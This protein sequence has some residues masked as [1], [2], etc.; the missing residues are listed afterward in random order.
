MSSA[1][2]FNTMASYRL[3]EMSLEESYLYNEYDGSL[4]DD[5]APFDE[6]EEDGDCY[7][8][9]EDD[10]IEDVPFNIVPG[11]SDQAGPS[12]QSFAD[13]KKDHFIPIDNVSGGNNLCNTSGFDFAGWSLGTDFESPPFVHYDDVRRTILGLE[14]TEFE[15]DDFADLMGK[16]DALTIKLNDNSLIELVNMMSTMGIMLDDNLCSEY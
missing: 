2:F 4:F 12:D 15:R 13:F 11:F 6:H 16:L 1:T 8:Y 3:A 5:Y 10:D 7:D 9:D 14:P